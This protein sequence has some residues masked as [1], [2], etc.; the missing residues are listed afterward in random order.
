[1]S[2]LQKINRLLQIFFTAFLFITFR[3]WHLA[4]IQREEKLEEAQRLERRTVVERATRG[5]IVD[6]FGIPLALNSACYV[7]TVI[8]SECAQLP[9]INWSI[10]PGGARVKQ[11]PRKEHIRRL[12][13]LLGEILSM[14]GERIEDLIHA[15]ASLLPH[16]PLVIRSSISETEY[17]RIKALEREWVGLHAELRAKRFYPMGRCASHL[18][19]HM[20]AI[21]QTEYLSTLHELK[22]LQEKA[23]LEEGEAS[24]PRYQELKEKAYTMNDFVGK[25]GL[26]KQYEEALRGFYGKK[27][28]EIDHQGHPLRELLSSKDPIPGETITLTLSAELQEFCEDL[29]IQS[30]KQREGRSIG[31]DAISKKRKSLKQPWIKGGAIVALDPNTG[32]ILALA[33]TPRFDPNDFISAG[34]S[35]E[36]L[37]LIRRS[38]ESA[39]EAADLWDGKTLLFRER[40]GQDEEVPLSWETYLEWLLPQDS[41]LLSFWHRVDD[42]KT[43]I[44]LQEDF[45]ALLYFA[46]A[47]SPTLLIDLLFP[48]GPPSSLSK[49]SAAEK[50]K[51]LS[52][53]SLSLPDVT[54]R[55]RRLESLLSSIPHNIDKLYALDLCRLVVYSP[56]FT[57]ELMNK[58]GAMKLSTYRMLTQSLRRIEEQVEK[59]ARTLFYL[60]EFRDWKTLNQKEFLLEKR[61]EEKKKKT[62]ARPYIDY[63]D[64]KE[65]ELFQVLWQEL[66]IPLLAALL[67]EDAA[68]LSPEMSVYYEDAMTHLEGWRELRSLSASL[69]SDE[70]KEWL[71]TMRPFAELDRPLWSSSKKGKEERHLA[72]SFYP[73]EKFGYMRSH[74]YQSAAPL[75]SIFK[76]VVAYAALKEKGPAIANMVIHDEVQF[77]AKNSLIVASTPD[78]KPF[79]RHYKGGRLPRSAAPHIGKIDL[80]GALEQTS[81]PY[82][83]LLAGDHLAEPNDLTGAAATLGFGKKSGLDL[84]FEFQGRLP[85]DVAQNRTGLYSFAIGQHTL[86]VTP[87]QAACFF[88]ILAN[89]GKRITPTLKEKPPQVQDSVFL[90]SSIRNI[91]FTGMDHVL[92]GA[93]GTARPSVIRNLIGRPAL[94]KSFLSLQHQM[95]GKTSTA[96]IMCRLDQNPSAPAQMYKHI[97]FGAISFAPHHSLKAKVGAWDNPELVVMVYLRYGD[98]GKEAAPLAAQVVHKWREI[99]EAH[100]KP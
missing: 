67:K 12:S 72:S 66:R 10:G 45:E 37:P 29:L 46:G 71:K 53:L 75:G 41:P 28:F 88:G 42:I 23:M 4:V 19:G 13:L 44:Q 1:M 78:H 95:I 50:E 86:V 90:P 15:K 34:E 33:S 77:D 92:W 83:S 82:F 69:N 52:R 48:E 73:T 93:K 64:Q 70:C 20:G 100:K 3:L 81:N 27:I 51:I 32:E 18:L 2:L 16:V 99:R 87:L 65:R 96:E 38:Q 9:R 6:R 31:I 76:L 7:A 36:K 56:S 62:Y 30:E 60:T 25:T 11:Y 55:R 59:K 79:Y 58:V 97:W 40:G 68:L 91:L 35:G 94:L 8:Y 43:A 26:E 80:V 98:G 84:P 24:S 22:E 39:K 21:S 89:S 49:S 14:D 54:P 61:K 63:L 57:D 17:Y 74:A 85:T 47:P 5:S